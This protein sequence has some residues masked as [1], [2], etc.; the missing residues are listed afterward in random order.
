[1]LGQDFLLIGENG[2]EFHGLS[3]F[4]HVKVGV[5]P[6]NEDVLCGITD[7]RP[8]LA[9]TFLQEKTCQGKN[10]FAAIPEGGHDNYRLQELLGKCGV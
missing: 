8:S 4:G 6:R 9:L 5:T 7:F 2:R 1:M 10:I 3:Q